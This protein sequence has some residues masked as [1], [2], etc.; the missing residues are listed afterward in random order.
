MPLTDSTQFEHSRA[1]TRLP[2][3]PGTPYGALFVGYGLVVDRL[4]LAPTGRFERRHIRRRDP[5][6]P[7]PAPRPGAF[8][9]YTLLL[10]PGEFF[11]PRAVLKRLKSS[12]DSGVQTRGRNPPLFGSPRIIEL[13]WGFSVIRASG[14]SKIWMPIP[15][16]CREPD[17]SQFDSCCYCPML[18][19][20]VVSELTNRIS[21]C[22]GTRRH[23]DLQETN[24]S[25]IAD[26]G[27]AQETARIGHTET[28][29]EC[30]TSALLITST[31]VGV[32]A[33][34]R[35]FSIELSIA[36]STTFDYDFTDS[37]PSKINYCA[38]FDD[39]LGVLCRLS[40]SLD[41]HSGLVLG[42]LQSLSL[43]F[44]SGFRTRS[45]RHFNSLTIFVVEL[46]GCAL[47]LVSLSF[48]ASR[49]KGWGIFEGFSI[50]NAR[51]SLGVVSEALALV[52]LS[53]KLAL[54]EVGAGLFLTFPQ[55]GASYS[56]SQGLDS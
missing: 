13:L 51:P 3:A 33:C 14:R 36:A 19:P 40:L 46:Q 32:S 48:Q 10:A 53:F 1:R 29:R 34:N 27:L 21:A 17:A 5:D 50:L 38:L 7:A 25:R 37:R 54:V 15:S 6:P 28:S 47:A 12:V 30:R 11:T 52:S 9:A 39:L 44:H 20:G 22:L 23:I 45:G 56:H 8:S 41:F 16:A 2:D 31:K 55:S 4:T 18:K 49:L 42:G 24:G 43:D 26:G 35:G